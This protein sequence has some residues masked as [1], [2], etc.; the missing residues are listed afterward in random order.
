MS[1]YA[2]LLFNDEEIA[3]REEAIIQIQKDMLDIHE[4]FR[5]L[6]DLSNQQGYL[7]DNIES[8]VQEV[9]INVERADDELIEADKQQKKKN[10]WLW[11]I[12]FVL[13]FIVLICALVLI[14]TIK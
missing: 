9:S 5:N 6:A 3:D 14:L 10:K 7:V 1:E 4:I 2:P 12:L 11:Y 13:L 8:N